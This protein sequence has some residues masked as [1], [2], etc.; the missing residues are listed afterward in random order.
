MSWINLN[1][2]LIN[3]IVLYILLFSMMFVSFS[4]I[5]TKTKLLNRSI[6]NLYV[7]ILILMIT[8]NI[9]FEL[10]KMIFFILM[11][12]FAIVL[13]AS[14]HIKVYV[15]TYLYFVILVLLLHFKIDE[16][17]ILSLN[18]AVMFYISIIE[19]KIIL[20]IAFILSIIDL[21]FAILIDRNIYLRI[22]SNIFLIIGFLEY[23]IN[24]F[25]EYKKR[26]KN[27]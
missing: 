20:I 2:V 25:K 9:I 18:L 8:R 23:G 4:L 24:I 15:Y 22:I 17:V 5:Y 6:F 14:K 7:F 11:S 1:I 10:D 12:F 3:T 13:T 26:E 19:R 27:A 21:L 16:K